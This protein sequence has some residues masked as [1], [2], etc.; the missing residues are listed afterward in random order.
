MASPEL[1]PEL[2]KSKGTGII[3]IMKIVFVCVTL[4]ILHGCS[5]KPSDLQESEGTGKLENQMKSLIGMNEDDV[6]ARFGKP[7]NVGSWSLEP[8]PPGMTKEQMKKW[9]GTLTRTELVYP[10]FVVEINPYG[11]V[12]RVGARVP[13]RLYG[14]PEVPVK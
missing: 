5:S 3:V 14:A 1:V 4:G 11:K 8:V 13:G 6:V 10:K 12:I 9:L 7:E 2:P